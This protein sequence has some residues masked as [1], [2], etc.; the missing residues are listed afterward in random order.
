MPEEKQDA[1][2]TSS[3]PELTE[4]LAKSSAAEEQQEQQEPQTPETETPTPQQGETQEQ[5]E[6]P[7]ETKEETPFHEHPRWQE[8][9][10]EKEWYKQQMER[11]IEQKESQQTPPPQQPQESNYQ[12]MTPEEERFWRAVDDRAA[13]IANREVQKMN[14]MLDAGLREIAEMKVSQFRKDHPDIKSNSPEE[15]QI[16]SRIQQG[17][18]PNDA[19][20]S[21]MGPQGIQKAVEKGK[22][23][24]KRKT[25]MKKQANVENSPSVS[26]SSQPTPKETIEQT[27]ERFLKQE[28]VQL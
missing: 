20:W 6:Q 24:V 11:M 28:G 2:E 26:S 4:A 13:K 14:P 17:Y 9:Q 8:V 18:L 16:A 25:E 10:R 21:V 1:Q 15:V 22:Q 12:N 19:Y 5:E 7:E 3:S 23:Q 27:F